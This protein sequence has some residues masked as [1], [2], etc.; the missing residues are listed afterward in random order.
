MMFTLEILLFRKTLDLNRPVCFLILVRKLFCPFIN[1]LYVG[2]AYI[3]LHHTFLFFA[4]KI[5]SLK[6]DKIFYQPGLQDVMKYLNVN[7]FLALL[8]FQV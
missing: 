1:F 4:W 8:C 3:I 7:C 2:V 6:R 5:I